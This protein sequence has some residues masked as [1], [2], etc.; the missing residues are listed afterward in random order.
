MQRRRLEKINSLVLETMASAIQELSTSELG[1]LTV[2]HVDVSPDLREAKIFIDVLGK[3]QTKEQVMAFLASNRGKLQQKLA[4]LELKYTPTIT[5]I[6][7]TGSENVN[8]IEEL[9]NQIKGNGE[10]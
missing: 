5:F 6:L 2:S 10:A 3:P 9:L 4:K 7:D 8:K 1:M